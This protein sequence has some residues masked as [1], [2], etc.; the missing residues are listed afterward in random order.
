MKADN[1]AFVVVVT[2][3]DWRSLKSCAPNLISSQSIFAA[4][5]LSKS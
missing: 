1:F 4:P 3:S 5:L 2:Q